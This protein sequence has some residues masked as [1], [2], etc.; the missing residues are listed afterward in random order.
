MRPSPQQRS[1]QRRHRTRWLA[2]AGAFATIGLVML[3]IGVANQPDPPPQPASTVLAAGTPPATSTHRPAP[4][5]SPRPPSASSTTLPASPPTR[6]DIPSL[7]V[8]HTLIRLG[9]NADHT[10][11]VPPLSDVATPSWYT[12]SPAP[13]QNGPAVILGHVDSATAGAGVFYRLGDLR[14]GDTIS[15]TRADHSIVDFTTTAIGDYPKTAFPTA[16]VYANTPDPQLRLIT[17]GGSFDTTT[18]N[19]RNN[20]VVYARQTGTR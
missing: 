1:G 15:I 13:G 19:Y 17:C 2:L 7:G 16:Q 6:L 20:I 9:L 18:H 5:R 3:G 10:L 14:P 4:D 11:R 12:G 8:H